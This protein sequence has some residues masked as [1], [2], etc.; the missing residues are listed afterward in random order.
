MTK[1][2][3][4]NTATTKTTVS[5]LSNPFSTGGG[6]VDFEHR[7]QATFLLALLVE[8]FSPLLNFPITSVLFQGK[9]PG[10][11]IDDIVVS[12]SSNTYSAKLLCQ[13]KHGVTITESNDTFKEVIVSAWSD[14]NKDTFDKRTD[15]IV[16]I[17]GSVARANSLRFIYDQANGALDA[18]DFLDRIERAGYSNDTN[19]DKLNIIKIFLRQANNNQEVTSEQLWEFCKAFTILVFDLDYESSINEF[20][21]RALIASNCKENAASVWA[22]LVDFAARS[23]RSASYITLEKIPEDIK[24]KFKNIID[25]PNLMPAALD[26]DINSFWAKLALIGSWSERNESDKIFLET[27]LETSYTEIQRRIQEGCLKPDPNISFSEGV[28]RVNHRRSIMKMCSTLYFDHDIKNFFSLSY[29]VLKEKDRRIQDN[30]EFSLLVPATGAFNHSDFLRNGIVQGLAII[31][32]MSGMQLSCSAET[33]DSEAITLIRNLFANSEK[34]VWMSLDS[35]LPDIAEINPAE[36]LSCLEKQII[37]TPQSIEALFPKNSDDFLFSRNFICSIL[38]SLEGLAWC[39]KYFIKCIRIL[40]QLS[41]LNY[42][43]TNS[44]NTPVNSIITIML[45]WHIQTLAS[46][47]KQ[48]S[49]IKALQQECPDI[50]WSVI[51]G[52]LPHTTQSTTGTHRSRYIISNMPKEVKTADQDILDLYQYYSRLALELAKEDYSKMYDLLPHYDNMDKD[53]VIEYL[54]LI[55]EKASGWEDSKKYPFWKEFLR[56][57]DW[58]IHNTVE[59]LDDFVIGRLESTIEKVTPTDI[60]YSYRKLYEPGYLDYDAGDFQTKWEAKRNEQETAVYNIYVAYGIDSVVEF[61]KEL[62][63]E[64]W[65]AQNLGKRLK[66]GEIKALLKMCYESKLNKNFFASIINGYIIVNGYDAMLQIDLKSYCSEYIAWVLSCLHPSMRLFEIAEHLLGEQIQLYWNSIVIPRFGLDE[67][68]DLNY[69]WGQLVEQKRYAAAINLFGITAE[70]CSV[71][72]DE[73]C[74]VLNQAAITE[75]DDRLDPDAV[76]NLIDLLQ[77][78]RSASIEDIS[79]I[80]LIYLLWLDDHSKVKP[81]ALRYR[82]A[83][84]PTFFCELVKLYYKKRHSETH[85]ENLSENMSKRLFRILYNFSVVPGTDWDGNYNEDAFAKWIDYCKSW[86]KAEDR[87]AVVQQTI[88]HGLSHARKHENGLVDDFIMKEL[89]KIENEEMRVGYRTGIFNQRGVRWVDPEGKPEYQLAEKYE[90]MADA[91]ESLGY[92]KYAETL[93]IISN[94]Y[95]K[96]AERIIREHRL[97]QETQKS[98]ND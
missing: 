53:T 64:A 58:L 98:E 93:R 41:T 4:Q 71:S 66:E 78:K 97:E 77:R 61:A 23:D 47:E 63:N 89:N 5:A 59:E 46:K 22:R 27:F 36:Y 95:T 79:H 20:L 45:P 35:Q 18:K 44:S 14:F 49:A 65:I 32:N 84:E 86:S 30:G 28:W 52:L 21:I 17:S 56:Q 1:K 6:G 38:W 7:V 16:L 10:Y 81:A 33:L 37:N 83:N 8:G 51:K 50:A 90:K 39:E 88:G 29:D 34:S 19:R 67:S 55:A 73:L 26:F 85:E 72:H 74:T 15:K 70:Q 54:T 11:D 42:E 24:Q 40:G 48:K 75:S 31:C 3:D 96:E 57:K 92:A 62:N 2:S 9:R 82:L 68:V 94:N 43:K 12:A 87:E 69:V 13:I 60:R 91:A 80:E 25:V 76:R